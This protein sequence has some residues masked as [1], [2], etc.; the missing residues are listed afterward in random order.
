MLIIRATANTGN[1]QNHMIHSAALFRCKFI[2]SPSHR[3]IRLPLSH[4]L[5]GLLE[6]F[7]FLHRAAIHVVPDVHQFLARAG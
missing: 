2:T 6:C 5:V 3:L 1:K 4:G 7:R